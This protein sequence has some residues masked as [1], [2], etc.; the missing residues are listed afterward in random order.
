[1]APRTEL[2]LRELSLADLQWRGKLYPVWVTTTGI[3]SRVPKYESA[4]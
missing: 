1:M 4:Y 2:Y 3:Q